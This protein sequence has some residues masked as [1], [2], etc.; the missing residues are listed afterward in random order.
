MQQILVTYMK[1]LGIDHATAENG[2]MAVQEYHR[3]TRPFN[4]V[5]MGI[6]IFRLL[7]N[8]TDKVTNTNIKL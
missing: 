7:T 5:L 4:L 3:T 2:L 1:K 6:A 8:P